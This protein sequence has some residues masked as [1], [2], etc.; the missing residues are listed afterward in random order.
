MI[1]STR[2][3]LAMSAV[4]ALTV[5]AAPVQ[6]MLLILSPRKATGLPIVWHRFVLKMFGIRVKIIGKPSEEHPLLLV[7]NHVSWKDIIVLGS[8]RPLSFIAKADMKSWPVLGPLAKLQRTI[9]VER[10]QRRKTGQQASQIAERLGNGDAIVLFAEGTT[11][12]G[13]KINPFN[14]SLLGAA[15]LAIKTSGKS[16]VLIQ[17]VAI[18]YTKMHGVALGRYFR[19]EAAWPGDVSLASHVIN[20]VKQGA[21]DVELHFGEPIPFDVRSN[22]KIITRQIEAEVRHML[23]TSLRGTAPVLPGDDNMD[24]PAQS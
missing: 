10:E 8:S 12:D 23:N 15:Q 4:L 9:F 17:P 6:A 13:N 1:A 22:R 24:D 2:L 21:L 5:V 3:V 16:S 18:A 11:S 7:A 14:S 19:P 20:I